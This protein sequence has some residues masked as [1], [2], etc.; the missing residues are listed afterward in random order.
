MRA[1]VEAA[2]QREQLTGESAGIGGEPT[3]PTEPTE[4]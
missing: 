1:E 4:I 3:A 2:R